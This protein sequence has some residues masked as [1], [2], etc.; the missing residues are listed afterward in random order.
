MRKERTLFI[1]G[2][3]VAILPYLGVFDS[4]RKIILIVTGIG[5]IYLAYLFNTEARARLVKNENLEKTF[6]ENI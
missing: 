2:I 5:I 6:V 1:I 3:W 4:W